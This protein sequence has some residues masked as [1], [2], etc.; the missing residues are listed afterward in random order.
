MSSI[1]SKNSEFESKDLLNIL[2]IY[3]WMILL[4]SFL[5]LLLSNVYLYFKPSVYSTYSIIEVKTRDKGSIVSDDLVQNAFYSTNKE[6]E[7]E[8]EILRTYDINRKVIEQM[9]FKTQ[10]F[11]INEY[12]KHELYAENKPLNINSIEVIDSEI[13]G[14]EIKITNRENGYSLSIKSSK[15]DEIFSTIL[16]K[17]LLYLD[18]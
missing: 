9:N 7:K 4:I 11:T 3:K 14:K 6:I 8:M 12:K 16:E 10:L 5:F 13:L 1:N 18:S 15:Q 17:K 2:G